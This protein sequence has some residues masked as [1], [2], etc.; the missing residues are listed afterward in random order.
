MNLH[1]IK[2]TC[3]KIYHTFSTEGAQEIPAS[4]LSLLIAYLNVSPTTVYCMEVDEAGFVFSTPT[5]SFR[6]HHDE[7]PEERLIDV[8]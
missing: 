4:E 1:A 2:S 7:K 8:V 5:A 6:Y 3:S